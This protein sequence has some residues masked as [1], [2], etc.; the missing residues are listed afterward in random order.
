MIREQFLTGVPYRMSYFN[1]SISDCT[2]L[3]GSVHDSGRGE[4]VYKTGFE[5][6]T[7]TIYRS[8]LNG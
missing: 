3:N 5:H 4:K 8:Y 2:E 6:I 7:R 1:M